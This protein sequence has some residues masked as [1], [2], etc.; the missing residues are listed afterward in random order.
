MI[1][2]LTNEEL[3]DSLT[4]QYYISDF[5]FELL[6]RLKECEK[7]KAFWEYSRKSDKMDFEEFE[8][9]DREVKND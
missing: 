2:D 7:Y 3:I 6:R 9:K 5:E 8:W 4:A 1:K